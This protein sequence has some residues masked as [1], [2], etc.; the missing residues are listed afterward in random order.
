MAKLIIC[1]QDGCVQEV[2][3]VD[4]GMIDGVVLIDRDDVGIATVDSDGFEIDAGINK[5]PIR[6]VDENDDVKR[7]YKKW[8]LNGEQNDQD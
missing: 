3:K 2:Y 8:K 4:D 7:L 6:C 5:M 1:V